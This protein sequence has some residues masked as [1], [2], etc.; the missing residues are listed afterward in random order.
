MGISREAM[1]ETQRAVVPWVFN[2]ISISKRFLNI[3]TTITT[4][5]TQI[6]RKENHSKKRKVSMR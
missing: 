5:T 3:P 4:M 6:I 1:F 2:I